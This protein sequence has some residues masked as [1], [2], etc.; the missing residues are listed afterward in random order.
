M[1]NASEMA[2]AAPDAR[3]AAVFMVPK[4]AR[5]FRAVARISRSASGRLGGGCVKVTRGAT[6]CRVAVMSRELQTAREPDK[7][8]RSR[9][10]EPNVKSA[11][12]A[13]LEARWG[14]RC[15]VGCAHREHAGPLLASFAAAAPEDEGAGPFEIT[16]DLRF[17]RKTRMVMRFFATY[18]TLFI[19]G[20]KKCRQEL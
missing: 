9:S 14:N 7:C 4:T 17:S 19:R 1:N 15:C 12:D 8:A 16:A 20:R 18:A 11:R 3:T 10:P 13:A 2:I 5:L 6:H